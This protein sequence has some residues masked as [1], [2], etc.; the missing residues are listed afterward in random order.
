M[1]VEVPCHETA[2]LIETQCFA[3]AAMT[4][5]VPCEVPQF[6]GPNRFIVGG[7][8]VL[9]G[10][11]E[12]EL[13]RARVLYDR[14]VGS[15]FA[16]GPVLRPDLEDLRGGGSSGTAWA[17][18]PR[19]AITNQHVINGV[20]QSELAAPSSGAT[21]V[22]LYLYPDKRSVR[23]RVVAADVD[24]DIAVI[25]FLDDVDVEPI[26]V[27][28]RRARPGD[29]VMYIG[30]PGRMEQMWIAGLGVVTGYDSDTRKPSVFSTVPSSEGASGSP[31]VNLDGEVIS[32][33]TGGTSRMCPHSE[34][35]CIADASVQY[36]SLPV[37]PTVTRGIDGPAIRQFFTRVTGESLPVPQQIG[38]P[39][40]RRI[41]FD[42]RSLG[43]FVLYREREQALEDGDLTTVSGFP[44]K[45]RDNVAALYERFADAVFLVEDSQGMPK[46]TAWL[47]GPTTVITNEHVSAPARSG[48]VVT[49]RRRDGS[50]LSAR[51]VEDSVPD[52]V[53]ILRLDTALDTSPLRIA[54]QNIEPD[55]PVFYIGHPGRMEQLWITG[56]G[57]TTRYD[58]REPNRM[59]TTLPGESGASGSPIF[60]LQG[61]V[62]ALLSY[63]TSGDVPSDGYPSADSSALFFSVPVSPGTGGVDAST[64]RSYIERHLDWRSSS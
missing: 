38:A 59:L 27:L 49:L 40:D 4:V 2:E 42:D 19:F 37:G 52:D 10:F 25:E 35:V 20:E 7:E 50:V 21:E 1:T 46:G 26:V 13:Q 61:D 57:V 43:A 62:V 32:L 36:S 17:I 41:V 47:A 5:E 29:P 28:D 33:L 22:L 16:V 48:D 64:L 55:E 3:D 60:N 12:G 30:N 11:P 56:L 14:I 9:S 6:A 24:L 34:P 44:A 15:V 23:G 8:P 31:I 63:N 51:V 58:L 39:D 54:P 18:H 53:T 45:E